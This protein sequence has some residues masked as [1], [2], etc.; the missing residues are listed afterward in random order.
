MG[1]QPLPRPW[2]GLALISLAL[3]WLIRLLSSSH[4]R[5]AIDGVVP[6]MP[7]DVKLT[8]KPAETLVPLT[9]PSRAPPAY[10][11]PPIPRKIWHIFFPLNDVV[12][13]KNVKFVADWIKSAPGYTYTLLGAEGGS[14][15]MAAYYGSES[16][17]FVL[18]NQLKNPALKSD[19]LRY[20]VLAAEG[21]YYADVDTRPL[22]PI[23]DWIDSSLRPKVRLVCAPEF[24]V[25]ITPEENPLY[26]IRFG[27][28]VIAGAPGH[29][30]LQR[31][32]RRA[33]D[34]VRD[35]AKAAGTTLDRVRPNNIQVLNATGPLP[36]TEVIWDY[37]REVDPTLLTDYSSISQLSEPRLVGDVLVMPIVSFRAP[38]KEEA[39]WFE[40]HGDHR[41]LE[42]HMQ[43]TWRFWKPPPE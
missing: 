9:S 18:F 22:L 40:E 20:H 16:E 34:G 28:W 29:P 17:Q 43:G 26:N 39:P 36:W 38:T 6:S 24:D 4:N 10:D 11:G 33:L 12:T 15:L 1:L 7:N 21:G 19:L 31:M 8:D 13:D 37:L 25:G 2:I 42:H 3:I 23:Q 41:V 27:Q 32:A 35:L 5:H 30:V 14:A